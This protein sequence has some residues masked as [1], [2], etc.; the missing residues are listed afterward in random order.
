[1][2]EVGYRKP[3]TE[4]RFNKGQSGNPAG[5]P[6]TMTRLD[7]VLKGEL[8]S[9]VNRTIDGQRRQ[10]SVRE[11]LV[12]SLLAKALGGD[13][14]AIEFFLQHEVEKE[15][16]NPLPSYVIK[17]YKGSAATP[18]KTRSKDHDK[19]VSRS[20][21]GSVTD[22]NPED[23]SRVNQQ[24]P[25]SSANH[26]A[27]VGQAGK[28][29]IEPNPN[30]AAGIR[31]RAPKPWSRHYLTGQDGRAMWYSSDADGIIDSVRQEDFAGLMAAGCK[32][33]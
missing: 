6:K 18:E 16:K 8:D 5:R 13:L 2:Y 31:M 24:P 14:G 21:S 19:P 11:S 4:S 32:R 25:E 15:A 30:P 1:M 33:V 23:A 10:L 22:Q 3:P 28:Q 17:Y 20:S 12:R 29:L 27:L 26:S 9:I 7:L